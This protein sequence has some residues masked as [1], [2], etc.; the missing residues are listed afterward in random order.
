[1]EPSQLGRLQPLPLLRVALL[2]ELSVAPHHPRQLPRKALLQVVHH[3]QIKPWEG[4]TPF[5]SHQA[6]LVL[7][8]L[9]QPEPLLQL[10]LVQFMV[11]EAVH[12]HR[13]YS[14]RRAQHQ[15]KTPMLQIIRLQHHLPDLRRQ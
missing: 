15:A 3:C 7:L 11:E 12:R 1:M 8:L 14:Q 6:V 9:S 4:I 10:L 13:L 5:L 2:H